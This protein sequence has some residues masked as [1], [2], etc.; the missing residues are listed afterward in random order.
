MILNKKK[1]GKQGMKMK[2]FTVSECDLPVSDLRMW[3]VAT[4]WSA[5]SSGPDTHSAQD[6]WSCGLKT[7]H[8]LSTS[9]LFDVLNGKP[10]T[11]GLDCFKA[12]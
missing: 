2:N 7:A 4:V 12:V 1:L 8:A 5:D 9:L 3:E 6:R 10:A 11:W